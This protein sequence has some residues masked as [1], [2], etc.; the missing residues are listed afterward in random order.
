MENHNGK[1]ESIRQL[2][3]ILVQAP[4]GST[5]SVTMIREGKETLIYQATV[6]TRPSG[7]TYVKAEEL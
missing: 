4:E 5:G 1:R 7:H 3:R 2:K 6:G